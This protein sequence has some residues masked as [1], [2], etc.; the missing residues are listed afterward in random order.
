M[1]L[2]T[3]IRQQIESV[4]VILSVRVGV[5][6]RERTGHPEVPHRDTELAITKAIVETELPFMPT[7]QQTRDHT[8]H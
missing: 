5:S 7:D 2:S 6:H 1:C 3:E 8:V 4:G